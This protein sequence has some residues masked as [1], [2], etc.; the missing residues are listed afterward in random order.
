MPDDVRS[1]D[2]ESAVR[3]LW[4]YLDGELDERRMNEVRYHLETC[5]ACLP[6]AD[7]GQRFLA[8]LRDARTRRLMPPAVRSQ[9]MSA[10]SQAGFSVS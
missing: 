7:F 9:V 2:C 10:L 5:Q 3:K 8:A 6:H 1:I 4:D